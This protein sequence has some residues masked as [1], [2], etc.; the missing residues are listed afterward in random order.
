MIDVKTRCTGNEEYEVYAIR[1]EPSGRGTT[2]V[3]ASGLSYDAARDFMRDLSIAVR[4]SEQAAT[5]TFIR[6]YVCRK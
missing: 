3:I 1:Y 5:E 6:A 4:D 2:E